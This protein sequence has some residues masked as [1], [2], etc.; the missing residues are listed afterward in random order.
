MLT[1]LEFFDFLK[2]HFDIKP[3]NDAYSEEECQEV[4]VV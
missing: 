2:S 1:P 3:T 4:C